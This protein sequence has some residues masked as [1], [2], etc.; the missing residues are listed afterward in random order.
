MGPPCYPIV[1][2]AILYNFNGRPPLGLAD[3]VQHTNRTRRKDYMRASRL[4]A[5]YDNTF[6]LPP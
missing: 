4:I 2:G 5:Y 3:K 6:P 1:Y